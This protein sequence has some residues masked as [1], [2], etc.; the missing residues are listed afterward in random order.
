[1][2]GAGEE[3][4]SRLKSLLL[5]WDFETLDASRRYGGLEIGWK[6]QNINL[7]NS[8]GMDSLLGIMISLSELE[9]NIHII[10]IYGPCQNRGPF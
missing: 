10:N 1:M 4:K 7:S 9:K 5:R 6:T 8:W 3:I 2:L